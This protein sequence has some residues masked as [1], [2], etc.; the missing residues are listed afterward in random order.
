[1]IKTLQHS[2]K[3]KELA[4]EAMATTVMGLQAQVDAL[5]VCIGT[6]EVDYA[7]L[8]CRHEVVTNAVAFLQAKQAS[9]GDGHRDNV[10]PLVVDTLRKN[11]TSQAHTAMAQR[12]VTATF[13]DM[14]NAVSEVMVSLSTEFTSL[15]LNSMH[16]LEAAVMG[17]P[18]THRPTHATGPPVDTNSGATGVAQGHG[19]VTVVQSKPHKVPS[20]R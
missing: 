11:K 13:G 2:V 10:M 1:M 6:A 4:V 17:R 5:T 20:L 16:W 7:D 8:L 12:E 15:N 14:T 3:S 9:S 19:R 18:A